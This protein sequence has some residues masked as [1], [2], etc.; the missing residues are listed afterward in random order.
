[1]ASTSS[2]ATTK[3]HPVPSSDATPESSQPNHALVCAV[4]LL[5]F[6]DGR[7]AIE[8]AA[9]MFDRLGLTMPVRR[10]SLVIEQASSYSFR[11]SELSQPI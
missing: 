7:N 6:V 4:I 8:L 2:I 3:Y 9:L 10:P 1:M 5:L 11:S